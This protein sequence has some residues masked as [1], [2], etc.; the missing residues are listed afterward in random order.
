MS[1]YAKVLRAIIDAG[2][3]ADR[4]YPTD[5]AV[6]R[7]EFVNQ[8]RQRGFAAFNA[9]NDCDEACIDIEPVE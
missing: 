3:A 1:K 4:K 2:A 5:S 8:L 7:Q 9:I 6:R